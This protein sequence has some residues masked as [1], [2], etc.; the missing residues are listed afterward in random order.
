MGESREQAPSSRK[1]VAIFLVAENAVHSLSG[2]LDRIPE[3]VRERA[4]E[5]LVC[6]GG[7]RDDTY[8]VGVGY[9]TV[10]GFQK[11]TV[12]RGS[13]AGVGANLKSA[14]D[15]C[16]EQGHEV[17]VLLHADGK[18]APEVMG[19]LI[20]PLDRDEVD[21]VVGSRFLESRHP[22]GMPRH[23]ALAIRLLSALQERLAGLGLSEYFCGYQALSVPAVA[24]LPYH[25]NRDDLVFPTEL[26]VQIRQ[27]GLRVAEVAVPP[28][29]GDETDGLRG[30]RYVAGV[31]HALWRFWLHSRGLREEPKFA[32]SEK[33]V[34]RREPEASHQRIL[35]LV[36]RD[37]Q[38]VL[39]VGCGAGY[40]AEALA[41]R[42][43]H[44][45]GVDARRAPGVDD[46]V[47]R[48]LQLDL[49]REPLEW[50][51][52]PFGLAV[53]AD[54]LE[55]L[56]EPDRLL[57]RCRELL[58]DDGRLIVSVP[59]V[60]HWT[61]R[62]QLLFGRFPYTARGILDRSHLRFFTLASL[63]E[64][65]ARA[66]FVVD[67]IETTAAPYGELLP[68]GMGSRLGRL[69]GRIEGIGAHFTRGVFAYQFVVR[70]RKADA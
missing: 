29:S 26:L 30:L 58:A 1:Q 57:A 21:V 55:H 31:L 3:D 59:N 47:E 49:D 50:S 52:P 24:E 53:L 54:V 68:R 8:L 27:K 7:S 15:R 2:V 70:A 20:E 62:L 4:A 45:V 9:K 18:Y 38:L 28:Y 39:D 69:L 36:E 11:L 35:G 64:E 42:G 67:R 13:D 16:R 65:L 12:M 17:V 40:L 56:R 10:S 43:N 60:A 34:Y 61:V 66:G 23:K 44:V 37:R 32:V 48:F 25:A 41:V 33:Y 63:R 22:A 5:I 19:T 14:I 46:R 51:G 6:A